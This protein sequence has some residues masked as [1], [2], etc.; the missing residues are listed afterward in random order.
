[1]SPVKKTTLKRKT[2]AKKP[3][4]QKLK[5]AKVAGKSSS[6]AGCRKKGRCAPKTSKTIAAGKIA[7][8]AVLRMSVKGMGNWGVKRITYM[9]SAIV[10]GLMIG[11]IVQSFVELIFL[12]RNLLVG[13]VPEPHT[14]LGAVSFL[15][16]YAGAF[17]MASGLCLGLSIGVW[18]W[19]VVYVQHKHRMF[20]NS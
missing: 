5:S 9:V 11:T 8:R 3:S 14:F 15:P 16:S 19:N 20:K 2:A 13:A 17:F 6:K 10:L 18:G 7:R 4:V 1:M 12:K